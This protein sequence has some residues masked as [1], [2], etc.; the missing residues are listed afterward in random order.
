MSGYQ[1]LN[2]F[3]KQQSDVCLSLNHFI[4]QQTD[5]C[6]S[7]NHFIKQQTDCV[8]YQTTNG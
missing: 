2:H 1:S 8:Y 6:L 4:K 5:V 7:L 3:I